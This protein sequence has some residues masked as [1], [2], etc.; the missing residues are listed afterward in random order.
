[1]LYAKY[2]MVQ[3]KKQYS[4]LISNKHR[5]FFNSQEVSHW[6]IEPQTT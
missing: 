3:K 2:L 4:L 1:M 5:F 6:G